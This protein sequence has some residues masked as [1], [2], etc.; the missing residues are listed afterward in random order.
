MRNTPKI[1]FFQDKTIEQ[2]AEM[3]NLLNELG[4]ERPDE[5]TL[6]PGENDLKEDDID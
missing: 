1:K 2:G 6:I 3:V 5:E 4:D